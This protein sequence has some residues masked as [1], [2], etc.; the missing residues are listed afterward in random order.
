[1]TNRDSTTDPLI[2]VST[3]S[4][5]RRRD[6]FILGAGFSKA[7]ASQMRTMVELGTEVRERLAEVT[8]LSSAIPVFWVI[9]SSCG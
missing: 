5:T 2:N 9:T 1:M 8:N 4:S 6:V 3:H 7:I